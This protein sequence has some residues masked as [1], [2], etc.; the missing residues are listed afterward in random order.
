MRTLKFLRAMVADH[1]LKPIVERAIAGDPA[2]QELLQQILWPGLLRIASRWRGVEHLSDA[3]DASPEISLRVLER[4]FRN[5]LEGLKRLWEAIVLGGGDRG[6]PYICRMTQRKAYQ[7][8]R[9]HPEVIG[10]TEDGGAQLVSLVPLTEREEEML[11]ASDPI[12]DAIDARAIAEYA[13]RTLSTDQL[14]AARLHFL[15][16]RDVEIKEALHLPSPE[17]AQRLRRSAVARLR[18][19]FAPEEGE[20]AGENR[21]VERDGIA[22]HG[23]PDK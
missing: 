2:A 17:V 21:P 3:E 10:Q 7:F 14:Q 13:E 1:V 5:G 6:W 11:P 22:W 12:P 9:N 23:L 18:R 19:R 4:L 20:G 16:D 8:V 15:G